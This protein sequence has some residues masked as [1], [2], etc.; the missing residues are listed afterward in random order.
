MMELCKALEKLHV[1]LED[2]HLEQYRARDELPLVQQWARGRA[3]YRV[4]LPADLETMGLLTTLLNR[5][6]SGMILRIS[7]VPGA[8]S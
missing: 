5:G 3:E 8:L 1:E 4:T 2:L 6:G 7:S